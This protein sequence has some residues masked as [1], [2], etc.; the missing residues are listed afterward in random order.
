MTSST[1]NVPF[2]DVIMWIKVQK[3][4]ENGGNSL[5]CYKKLIRSRKVLPNKVEINPINSLSTNAWKLFNQ[6]EA[7]KHNIVNGTELSLDIRKSVLGRPIS[8][9]AKYEVNTTSGLSSAGKWQ[10]VV[11]LCGDKD[12]NCIMFPRRTYPSIYTKEPMCMMYACSVFLFDRIN[13]ELPFDLKIV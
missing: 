3:V 8:L 5:Q 12:G 9:P 7:N 1:E 4:W 6:L 2:H 11:T 10:A 13:Y